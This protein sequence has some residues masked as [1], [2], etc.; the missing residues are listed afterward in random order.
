MR[1]FF[2]ISTGSSV[3]HDCHGRDFER[4]EDARELAELIALDLECTD[5]RDWAGSEIRVCNIY[6][7]RLFS[8]LIGSTLDRLAA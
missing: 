3:Q 7:H 6:G 1:C 2:D 4:V 5:M 8:V